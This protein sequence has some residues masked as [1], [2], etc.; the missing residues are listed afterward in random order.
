MSKFSE[1]L[2]QCIIDSGMT[3][4][5]LAK[6]SGFNRSYIALMKNGQRISPDTGKMIKLF[7]NLK[8]SPYEYDELWKEYIR[9][10]MGEEIYER[11]MAVLDFMESFG[12]ISNISI[13]SFFSHEIPDIRTVENRMDLEYLMRAVMEREYL[14]KDGFIH[15]IMQADSTALLSSLYTIYKYNKELPAEHIICLENSSAENSQN[16]LYNIQTLKN[17]MPVAIL[18]NSVNYQIYYYYDKVSAHL[19]TFSLMPYLIITSECVLNINTSVDQG[20]LLKDGEIRE[21]YENMFQEQKMNCRLLL[22]QIEGEADLIGYYNSLSGKEEI[23]YSIAQQPCVGVLKLDKL[24]K[25]YF[26]V[27]NKQILDA[28]ENHLKKN[29]RENE[30]GITK[31]VAFCTKSGLKR[32]ALEGEIDELPREIYRNIEAEDR[33]MILKMLRSMIQKGKY[34]LYLLDEQEIRFP[35][36]LFVNV[37][38]FSSVSLAYLS[39]KEKAR[40]ILNEGSFSKIMYEFC[41]ELN[42]TP[43]VSG[44]KAVEMFLEELIFQ[45]EQDVKRNVTREQMSTLN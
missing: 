2:E 3:E 32:L 17:L 25:K 29:Y 30:E 5:Q 31:N 7:E 1:H 43:Q 6:L 12:N 34:E 44:G 38:G 27:E 16:Q 36:E 21:L 33:I 8:L 22:R 15:I 4:N 13:K 40:F 42:K 14:K 9:A 41:E 10:R 18:A 45:V 28:M 39:E 20:I 24:V 37:C 19:N 11:N 23:S 26:C 35:R